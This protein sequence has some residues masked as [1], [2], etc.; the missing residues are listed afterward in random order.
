MNTPVTGAISN[1]MKKTAIADERFSSGY[2][3]TTIPV[4]T[5][6]RTY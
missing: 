1:A 4:V 3:S 6:D 2:I 5:C